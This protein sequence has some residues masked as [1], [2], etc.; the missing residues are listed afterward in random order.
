MPRFAVCYIPPSRSPFYRLGTS[1]VRYDVRAKTLLHSDNPIRAQ[2]PQFREEYVAIPQPHGLHNTIVGSYDFEVGNLADIEATIADVLSCF[3]PTSYFT[4]RTHR[5]FISFM[6]LQNEA[7][8]LRYEPNVS[9]IALHTMLLTALIRYATGSP[10]Y[11]K[12]Q[13]DKAHFSETQWQRIRHFYQ[14]HVLDGYNPH[15][16]LLAPYTDNRYRKE[17]ERILRS[18]FGKFTTHKLESICLMVQDDSSDYW[19]IQREFER[20]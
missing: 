16:T 20:E 6:G 17:V 10:Y 8:V 14:P 11:P 18:L 4:L 7:V 9:L 13:D 15:F 2:I 19:Y 1:L 5:D 3:D 12:Y